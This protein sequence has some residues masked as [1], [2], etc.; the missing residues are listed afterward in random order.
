MPAESV[1]ATDAAQHSQ[2]LGRITSS[3]KQ[4]IHLSDVQPADAARSNTARRASQRFLRSFFDQQ[5]FEMRDPDVR[6]G[7]YMRKSNKQHNRETDDGL[8]SWSRVARRSKRQ[9]PGPKR[10]VLSLGYRAIK[11]LALC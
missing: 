6:R 7:V 2:N 5:D 10:R 9:R 1:A 11:V 8:S 3:S 4:A